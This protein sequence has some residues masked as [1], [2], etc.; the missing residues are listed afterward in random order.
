MSEQ[1]LQS[2]HSL[3]SADIMAPTKST[4]AKKE[5]VFHPQSRK[6]GQ[7]ERA[8]LRKSK[9]S[10]AAQKKS[11]QASSTSQYAQMQTSV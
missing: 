4:K 1:N 6:A 8:Q 10:E 9:L 5:K 7:M 11:K 2:P 3:I